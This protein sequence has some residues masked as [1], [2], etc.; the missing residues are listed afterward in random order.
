MPHPAVTASRAAGDEWPRR[1]RP[2]ERPGEFV[3]EGAIYRF[4]LA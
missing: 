2:R 3:G 1:L 4:P